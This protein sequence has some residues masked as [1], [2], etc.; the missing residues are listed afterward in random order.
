MNLIVGSV[1]AGDQRPL[2]IKAGAAGNPAGGFPHVGVRNI[3][4]AGPPPC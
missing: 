2:G 4:A 1:P 3:R